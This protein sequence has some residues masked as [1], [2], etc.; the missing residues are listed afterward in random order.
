MTTAIA[1]E[2]ITLAWL[3]A[4]KQPLEGGTFV[5]VITLP[6][7]KHYAV[8]KL[9]DK[10]TKRLTWKKAMAW[11]ESVGGRLPS[12][13]IAALM[14]SLAKDLVTPDWYWTDEQDDDGYAWCCHFSHGNQYDLP[15]GNEGCAVAVRMIPLNP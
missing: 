9:D 6:D 8:V 14:F 12:R 5:G 4:L 11:A 3:P 7:G 2:A 1:L 13:A 15:Q 10:P